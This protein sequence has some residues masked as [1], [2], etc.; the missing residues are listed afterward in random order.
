[1][2]GFV[3]YIGN[4]K[5]IDIEKARLSIKN[6]GPDMHG[7]VSTENWKVAF[8]RLSIHDLSEKGMQPFK[9]DDIT[10]YM[11]GEIFNYIELIQEEE[12]VS[13]SGS[14]V[15]I[16][17]YLY[18]KYGLDF[19][20]RLNGMFAIVIIDN[21][22]KK[23]YF[24]RDR[25]AEKP[26]YYHLKNEILYFSSEVKAIKKM[27]NLE[28]DKINI[29][30]NLTS[31]FLPQP[32]TLYK[33]TFNVNPGSYL[34]YSNGKIEEKRWYQPIIEKSQES[35]EVIK[36]KFLELYRSSIE[37]RLRSDVPVGI[38]LSGGLDST[39]MAK[40]ANSMNSNKF[41]AFGSEIVGKEKFENNTDIEVPKRLAKDENFNYSSRILDF[42]FYNKN[43]VKIINNYD[44]ILVNSGVLVFYNLAELSHNT[45]VPVILTGVGGDE[46]FG[47]Y[48]W[49]GHQRKIN[50]FFQ[51]TYNKL[52]YSEFIYSTLLKLNKKLAVAYKIL[53]DF[54]VWHSQSLAT[55]IFNFDFHSV[56]KKIE[57]RI[58]F[59]SNRYFNIVDKHIDNDIYNSL[60][61]ANI[62]TVLGAGQ[63]FV[64]LATMKFSVENRS[65]FLDYRLFEYM[66]SIPDEVKTEKGQ[67]GLLREILEDFLPDYVTKAK[68]SGPTMPINTWFYEES[69]FSKLKLFI[70]NN[71]EII[72]KFLP[73]EVNKL[74][75]KDGNWLFDKN[76]Q[77]SN[78]RLFALI[79][80]II[81]YKINI[82]KEIKDID[83]TFIDLINDLP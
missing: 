17:P 41:Y 19:L 11:N 2:C 14:D 37:L 71:R 25:F 54:Q 66:M 36:K 69:I 51:K 20:N 38:F 61:Y 74:I 63:H 31:W 67:K 64:D 6:R 59:Y 81:W 9:L 82:S 62:W 29:Q 33:N 27:V 45:K 21:I 43:I 7:T 57:E 3:G 40:I 70:K 83:L 39:S 47:G 22:K 65:P 46:L 16:I 42:D 4:N 76:N 68:K 15:E 49:Q 77:A 78:L 35:K 60:N 58:R 26:L 52:P 50:T 23:T 10:V 75:T 32:L 5:N 28:V 30:I 12:F 55:V 53:T 24:I 13:E 1:M 72:D 56:R 18:S 79:S 8:N 80:Y 34:E 48:P 44:E 73:K